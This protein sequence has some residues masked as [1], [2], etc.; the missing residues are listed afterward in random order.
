MRDRRVGLVLGWRWFVRPAPTNRG[1]RWR[2][3][4]AASVATWVALLGATLW[5]ANEDRTDRGRAQQPSADPYHHRFQVFQTDNPYRDDV[6][7]TIFMGGLEDHDARAIV[8]PPGVPTF[9]APGATYVSPAVR[10]AMAHDP[11]AA[12]RVPGTVAGTIG[13]AGLQSPDQYLV[14]TGAV[15]SHHWRWADG[16]GSSEVAVPRE[17]IPA[18]PLVALVVL[19]IGVPA[20]LL[21]R[22]TGRM[23]AVSRQRSVAACHLLGLPVRMLATASGVEAS[24]CAALGCVAG[25]L[26]T[27]VTVLAIHDTTAFGIEWY[28]PRTFVSP[29]AALLT[30]VS[31][32]GLITRDAAR[33]TRRD[34]RA[35]LSARA[36]G[37]RL[38]RAWALAPLALGIAALAGILVSAVVVGHRLP[39]GWVVMYLSVGV[40]LTILGALAGLPA[41]L[42]LWSRHL[43]RRPQRSTASFVAVRRLSWQRDALAAAC[44][45]LA[46]VGTGSLI[47]A[48]ALA[49]LDGV[50]IVNP[51]GDEW[52]V[53]VVSG[54]AELRAALDVRIP[55]RL[56]EHLGMT[57]AV[58][59]ADCSTLSRI[60][61]IDAPSVRD[62]FLDQ[63]RSG[64][65][66]SVVSHGEPS[67]TRVVLPGYDGMLS[68]GT[69]LSADPSRI[70]LPEGDTDIVAFPGR[71]DSQVDDYVSRV[72]AVAPEVQVSNLSAD[73]YAP[74]VLPTR[75][76]LI[77]CT[78]AGMLTSAALLVL[79]A[80]DQHRRSRVDDARLVALGATQRLTALIHAQTF[81]RGA[82]AALGIGLLVGML[83]GTV[84]DHV[85]GIV[86][87][88]GLL[89]VAFSL[90]SVAIAAAAILLT[91]LAARPQHRGALSEELRRD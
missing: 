63:C 78:V 41:L 85:G 29:V 38:S 34:L 81:G 31:L 44:I 51:S 28:T 67:A 53:Q 13:E 1:L 22:A 40:P 87:G 65:T 90:V 14:Y 52:A 16:W 17:S 75:R 32:T 58:H 74:M 79:C 12:G 91:W 60:V 23:A 19:L 3:I 15:P 36:G 48:G 56:L 21:A 9:L 11:L 57:E 2:R 7:T 88:P 54:D 70:A 49:D 76:L 5:Q 82:V 71:Q 24:L 46:I 61:A 72:T 18:G 86:D 64:Q 84:Y 73:S 39:N 4:V 83:A 6:W 47:G 20:I 37:P 50:S 27:A 69:V 55:R 26:A 33:S 68:D 45:G 89:G 59:V 25:V 62:R 77:A 10:A 80:L 43:R 66:F 35:P 30:C 8:T 42:D